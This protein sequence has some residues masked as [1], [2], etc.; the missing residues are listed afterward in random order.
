MASDEPEPDLPPAP[1]DPVGAELAALRV[2]AGL[3]AQG[4]SPRV[5][6]ETVA[7]HVAAAVGAEH[8]EILEFDGEGPAVVLAAWS[9]ADEGAADAGGRS[10]AEDRLVARMR[11]TGRPV[12]SVRPPA[13]R[14]A[15][16][17][18]VGVPILIEDRVWGAVFAHSGSAAPLPAGTETRLEVFDELVT[19]A[20][21]NTRAQAK[22]EELAAYQGALLR[23]AE[24][25]ARGARPEDVF[26]VVA[27][28]LG[29][30]IH[31]Q[32]AKMV[33]YDA[34]GMATFLGSWG[35]L[36][37]GIPSGTRLRSE[38]TSV[39]G[40]IR[41]TGG[42][43]RVDDY[44]AATG[45]IAAIQRSVGMAS[46]VGAPIRV[47]GRIWGALIVGSVDGPP[48][49]SGTERRM[50]EFADLV[51]IAL[52]NLEARAALQ[53]LVEEQAALNRLAAVVAREQWDAV[54][55][56]AARE[57]RRLLDA[58]GAVVLRYEEDGSATTLAS[59][60][61]DAGGSEGAVD[62]TALV[63]QV[64][65]DGR[66][67][68]AIAAIGA[69]EDAPPREM[70]EQVA[71]FAELLSTAIGN[72]RSR[73]ELIESRARIVRTADQTR[74]RFERDL[75]DGV[76]QRLVAVTV[77]IRQIQSRLTGADRVALSGLS[78]VVD[79]L[80]SALD[81][82]RELAQGL[83]PAILTEEGLDP[84]IRSLARRSGL[85]VDVR[86]A[87]IPRLPAAI[88]VAAYYVVSEGLANA[89]KHADAREVAITVRLDDRV[90]L[91][92]VV[93]DGAGGADPGRGS[94]LIGIVDRVHVLGGTFTVRSPAGQGTT[95]T[96][97]FPL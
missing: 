7:R 47:D 22:V 38:G 44:G 65:V 53:R 26:A 84:A 15:V 58:D 61:A 95:L 5:V 36:Q 20:V 81:D 71:Q 70:Q 62:E 73:L 88:E 82:L 48:L 54:F 76:Q 43:A 59:A 67:W 32:G 35:R 89:A 50:S 10:L 6:L 3:V 21:V 68:G 33:R 97:R 30:L 85:V 23:V 40:L 1:A 28:E 52:S 56:T 37:A 64:T 14:T 25:V 91:V 92:E 80:T 86:M 90:L 27:E 29:R 74:R 4:A 72:M 42:P 11:R 66:R 17:S 77:R 8:L 39:T 16:T 2:A 63:C 94:G 75:H 45:E 83:H 51:A 34:D 9:R 46:A 31:V 78:V 96:A 19:S 55:P 41:S 13:D 87:R 93:D 57:V 49:P 18:S 69:A 12:R 60:G 79:Q 24:L